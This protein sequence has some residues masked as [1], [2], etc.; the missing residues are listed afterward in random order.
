MNLTSI[1]DSAHWFFKNNS[2]FYY[3]RNTIENKEKLF[4]KTQQNFNQLKLEFEKF[5][6]TSLQVSLF[7]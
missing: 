1:F 6:Q 4:Y 7:K 2:F 3:Y 5:A